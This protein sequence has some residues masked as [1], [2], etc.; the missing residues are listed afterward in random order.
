MIYEKPEAF[1][2]GAAYEV[3]LGE[4]GVKSET[5]GDFSIVIPQSDFDE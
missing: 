2:I 4:K 3:V 5:S 1:E